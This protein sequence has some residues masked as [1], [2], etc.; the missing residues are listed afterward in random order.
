METRNEKFRAKT[1]AV[2]AWLVVF[3]P[4]LAAPAQGLVDSGGRVQSLRRG[5]TGAFRGEYLFTETVVI[6]RS[7]T[8]PGAEERV[9][10]LETNTWYD[11]H[12]LAVDPQ[13]ANDIAEIGVQLIS[14]RHLATGDRIALEEFSAIGSYFIRGGSGSVYAREEEGSADW[15]DLTG[16]EGLGRTHPRADP[17]RAQR[18]GR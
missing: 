16:T 4:A 12:A 15:T 10:T 5:H 11:L 9:D 17:D 2:R 6:D 8:P 18:R 14:S 13:G 7:I 1:A 3:L